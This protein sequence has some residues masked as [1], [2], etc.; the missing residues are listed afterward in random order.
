LAKRSLVPKKERKSKMTRKIDVLIRLTYDIE[1]DCLEDFTQNLEDTNKFHSLDWLEEY[2][3]DLL[4]C[5]VRYDYQ[6]KEIKNELD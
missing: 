2:S 3:G 6:R 4:L 5:S 1:D